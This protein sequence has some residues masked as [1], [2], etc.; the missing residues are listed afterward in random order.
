MGPDNINGRLTRHLFD[1]F[2]TFFTCLFNNCIKLG[3]F[4]APWKIANLK[5]IPKSNFKK[6]ASAYRPI[7]LLPIIGKT[8]ERVIINGLNSYFYQN[9]LFNRNQ[10]GFTKQKSTI[11]AL[12]NILEFLNRALSLKQYALTA[13]LDVK[14][15]FDNVSWQ[16]ILEQLINKKVPSHLVH[17]VNNYFQSRQVIYTQNN[18]I[19]KA[20]PGKGCPQGSVCGPFLWN[21]V[22]SSLLERFSSDENVLITAFADDI[23]LQVK[24]ECTEEVGVKLN[25]ILRQVEEWALHQ[26]LI[27]SFFYLLIIF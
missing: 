15:R 3:H 22:C 26:K 6:D 25:S 11:T 27:I 13:S 19:F 18:N 4:P 24:G 8:L 14:G 9:D 23:T 10:H 1:A 16:R 5:I 21:L 17:I 12:D 20:Y 7:C 2:P